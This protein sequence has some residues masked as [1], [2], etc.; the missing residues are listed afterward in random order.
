M[1]VIL[2]P[3]PT[4]EDGLRIRYPPHVFVSQGI[5]LASAFSAEFALL[6]NLEPA[7][8]AARFVG[9]FDAGDLLISLSAHVVAEHVHELDR[10][11]VRKTLQPNLAQAVGLI[12]VDFV[13]SLTPDVGDAHDGQ[14]HNLLAWLQTH[15][16]LDDAQQRAWFKVLP[17]EAPGHGLRSSPDLILGETAGDVSHSFIAGIL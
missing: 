6:G 2:Q 9:P 5:L 8:K 16:L 12:D 17:A 4:Y 10:G 7:G 11:L 14:R 15:R 3:G 1:L 13:E